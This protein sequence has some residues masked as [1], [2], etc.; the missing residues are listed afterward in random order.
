MFGWIRHGSG[1]AAMAT[2]CLIV[3]D[4]HCVSASQLVSYSPPVSSTDHPRTS[5]TM[6]CSAVAL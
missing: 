4:C 5:A 1:V 6:H 2:D 3:C